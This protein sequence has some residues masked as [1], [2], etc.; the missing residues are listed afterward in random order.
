MFIDGLATTTVSTG[1]ANPFA[2][3]TSRIKIHEIL[4]FI[5]IILIFVMYGIVGLISHTKVK[6]IS[7]K[8]HHRTLS[9]KKCGKSLLFFKKKTKKSQLETLNICILQI[10]FNQVCK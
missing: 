8:K 1:L 10:K 3:M 5:F 7:E 6:I 4:F 9:K 2:Q